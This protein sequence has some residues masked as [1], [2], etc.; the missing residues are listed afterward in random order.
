MP[1]R[2][3]MKVGFFFPVGGPV[4]SVLSRHGHRLAV[5]AGHELIP[6]S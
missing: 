4:G 1:R 2:D 5:T 3:R 6:S